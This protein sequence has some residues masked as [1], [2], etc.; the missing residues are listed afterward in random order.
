[1]TTFWW[2]PL[3]AGFKD[4]FGPC[5]L[6]T[7]A[8]A[9]VLYVVLDNQKQNAAKLVWQFILTVWILNVGFDLGFLQNVTSLD[10]FQST[11]VGIYYAAGIILVLA[12]L[13]LLVD[14]INYSF[15]KNPKDLVIDRIFK[16]QS[17]VPVKL[18]VIVIASLSF[19]ESAKASIWPQDPQVALV[20]S[21]IALPGRY[22]PSVFLVG[23]Y[24]LA[25]LWLALAVAFVCT[26]K[27]MTSRLRQ[28]LICAVF[29]AA[30]TSIFYIF[31]F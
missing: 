12:G 7:A 24:A 8:L 22:W 30:A 10:L 23:L 28:L 5:A 29:F 15:G 1:M 3:L 13:F 9:L 17:Q 27:T 2:V 4:G 18:W 11:V 19:L 14:W 6:K 31:K 20:I 25:E 16:V 21:N 26:R